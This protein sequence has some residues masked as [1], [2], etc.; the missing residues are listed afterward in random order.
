[1]P[2]IPG[3]RFWYPSINFG[4]EIKLKVLCL[5]LSD[6]RVKWNSLLESF[7]KSFFSLVPMLLKQKIL[8]GFF[9]EVSFLILCFQ[10]LEIMTHFLFKSCLGNE[11]WLKESTEVFNYV[12]F[13]C[14]I[15][16]CDTV[17]VPAGVYLL[18][19]NK[20]N[21][22]TRF[23]ICWNLTIKTPERRQVLFWCLYC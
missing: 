23:E 12:K 18:K 11:T 20:R 9:W 5:V 17:K 13:I 3:L 10:S 8:K 1:M 21:T 2:Q 6:W 16:G 19:V 22:R 7:C 15:F 4:H 14:N